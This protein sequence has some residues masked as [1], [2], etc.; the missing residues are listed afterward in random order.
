M[1]V[2][3]KIV[4]E[5]DIKVWP[6]DPMQ[7]DTYLTCPYDDVDLTPTSATHDKETVYLKAVMDIPDNLI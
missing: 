4:N 7:Y 6:Q 1:K 3:I 2:L 5:N